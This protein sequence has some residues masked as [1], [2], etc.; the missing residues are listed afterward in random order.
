MCV[1]NHYLCPDHP[2]QDML[3]YRKKQRPLRVRFLDGAVKTI[4]VDDSQNVVD[5][6]KAICARIGESPSHPLSLTPHT[7]SLSHPLP[8]TPYI[9]S[10]T[11]SLSAEL[12]EIQSVLCACV[13]AY[14]STTYSVQ[15]N[16]IRAWASDRLT[17][18][19][20]TNPEEFSFTTEEETSDQ[21]VRRHQQYVRDQKRLDS[22]KKKLHTDDECECV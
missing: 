4:L 8:L 3:E 17:L 11:L 18:P 5:L 14:Y 12:C 20:L 16:H 7:L 22:L 13:R 2:L 21:T 6:T 15:Y 9:L 1:I 19:G 10:Y